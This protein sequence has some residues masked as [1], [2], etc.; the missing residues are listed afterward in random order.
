MNVD[1]SYSAVLFRPFKNEVLDAVCTLATSE[2]GIMCRTG[3]CEIFVSHLQM[4]EDIKFNH[5]RGDC[6]VSDDETSTISDGTV[7]RLRVLGTVLDA[8]A[9]K[10]VGTLNDSFLG[11]VEDL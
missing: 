7:V 9:I 5:E 6:W 11:Q 2:H 10:V 4:P 8:G 3:P 1:V